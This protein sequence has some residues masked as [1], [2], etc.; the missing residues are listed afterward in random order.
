MSEQVI[1][2]ST[3]TIES[4]NQIT[5]ANSNLGSQFESNQNEVPQIENISIDKPKEETENSQIQIDNNSNE[6]SST[7][8]Q[9]SI[10][11]TSELF[12]TETKN[13]NENVLNSLGQSY[14]EHSQDNISNN[15]NNSNTNIQKTEETKESVSAQVNNLPQKEESEEIDPTLSVSHFIS[16]LFSQFPHKRLV[17]ILFCRL[18]FFQRI[19]RYVIFVFLGLIFPNF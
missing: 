2:N 13:N 7:L 1:N 18:F 4:T 14:D 6:N 8:V 10:T 17:I 5:E 15:T 11:Q 16:I 9:S 12:P 3:S 19:Q